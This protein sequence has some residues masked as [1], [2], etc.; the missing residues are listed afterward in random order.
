[1][2]TLSYETCKKIYDLL[3]SKESNLNEYEFVWCQYNN[4]KKP[5]FTNYWLLK[6]QYFLCPAYTV[7]D[8]L[9]RPFLEALG[10]KLGWK[11]QCLLS[12]PPQDSSDWRRYGH[13]LLEAYWQSQEE[14]EQK[15]LQLIE[16]K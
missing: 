6:T 1:M 2:K 11:H 10:E 15:L 14:F 5:F 4:A 12:D 16:K 7:Q 13:L 3:G 9:S 8:I